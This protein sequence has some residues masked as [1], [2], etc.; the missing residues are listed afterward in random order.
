MTT[1]ADIRAWAAAH[2]VPCP[3]RGKIPRV[4]L[5]AHAAATNPTDPATS[6]VDEYDAILTVDLPPASILPADERAGIELALAQAFATALASAITAGR[7]L[8]RAR[9][10]TDLTHPGP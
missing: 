9:I 6:T 8:E 3:A 5:D 2:G 1:N 7:R 4:V 10:L